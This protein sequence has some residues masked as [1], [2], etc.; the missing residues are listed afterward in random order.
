MISQNNRPKLDNETEIFLIR[1]AVTDFNQQGYFQ[2]V[3]DIP[4][5]AEGHMQAQALKQRFLEEKVQLDH[6]YTSY[7]VR[8]QETAKPL[9]DAFKLESRVLD[10]VHELDGGKLEGMHFDD[11]EK[12]FPD[13]LKVQS[14]RPYFVEAPNGETGREVHKRGVDAFNFILDTHRGETTSIVSHGLFLQLL[15]PYL[16]GVNPE[17]AKPFI[18]R[19]TAVTRVLISPKRE[20]EVVYMHDYSH[21][22]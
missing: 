2:G 15:M 9:A 20:I 11:I 19:N 3:S 4:I 8:T 12:L 6:I 1:H 10:G 7:L 13:Y 16:H 22:L 21:M 14:S 5:N 18:A 17:E